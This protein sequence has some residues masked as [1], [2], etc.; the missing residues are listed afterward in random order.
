MTCHLYGE[1]K[2]S[3]AGTLKSEKMVELRSSSLFCDGGAN[4]AYVR[5]LP[6]SRDYF[7]FW[8]TSR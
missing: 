1:E 8:S 6:H 2:L 7:E 5:V 3:G 4:S